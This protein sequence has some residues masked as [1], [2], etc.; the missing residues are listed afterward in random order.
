MK[1]NDNAILNLNTPLTLLYRNAFSVEGYEE[2]IKDC[3]EA[4]RMCQEMMERKESD[5]KAILFEVIQKNKQR[6]SLLKQ[7]IVI[8]NKFIKYKKWLLKNSH[9]I[10]YMNIVPVNE[11]DIGL[12]T[13]IVAVSNKDE[14]VVADC[15]YAIR[16]TYSDTERTES[17]LEELYAKYR[18][19]KIICDDVRLSKRIRDKYNVEEYWAVDD[20]RMQIRVRNEN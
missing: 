9:N 6:I 13:K 1:Q 17:L 16:T 4:I 15:E 10:V 5:G 3:R 2:E 18:F 8:C 19:T 7:Q 14:R 20:G 11:V 12:Y